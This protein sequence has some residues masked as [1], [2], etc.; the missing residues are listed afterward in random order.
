M[1]FG[2][3]SERSLATADDAEWQECVIV[4]QH[5]ES[6]GVAVCV[7]INMFVLQYY[8]D[9]DIS[10]YVLSSS[11]AVYPLSFRSLNPGSK[12]RHFKGDFAFGLGYPA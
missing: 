8:A 4:F 12:L 6:Q 9:G 5:R 3:Q 10:W 11:E 1:R 2:R 7:E